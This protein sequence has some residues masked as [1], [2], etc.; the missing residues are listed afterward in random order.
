MREKLKKI[1]SERY[2]Q[3]TIKVVVGIF[4]IL[5][6]VSFISAEELLQFD[7]S[8]SYDSI[9]KTI[10]I[11]NTFGLGR[12]IADIKLNTPIINKVGYGGI[13]KVAEFQV[14]SYENYTEAIE[15]MKFYNMN[16]KAQEIP[17][18]EFEY[19]V[20]G[21]EEINVND[22]KEVC[23]T[24]NK[25]GT[26][27]DC[28]QEIVGT[29][30]ETQEVWT[31]LSK[32]DFLKD[33]IKT[34]GIYTYVNKGDNVEW[35]MN[36]YGKELT[37]WA[38]W[39]ASL[40]SGLIAYYSFDEKTGTNMQNNAT[41]SGAG[42]LYNGTAVNGTTVGSAGKLGYSV[43]LN[44][45]LNTEKQAVLVLMATPT[46][47]ISMCA[48]I[49]SQP[50]LGQR[51][52]IG[53]YNGAGN[54]FR[55]AQR[56]SST[57]NNAVQGYIGGTNVIG[58]TNTTDNTFH[59]VCLTWSDSDDNVSLYTDGKLEDTDTKTGALNSQVGIGIGVWNYIIESVDK[60]FT[61][62]IDEVGMW[63]RRLTDAEITNLYNGGAGI[64]YGGYEPI[65]I[66][67][68]VLQTPTN[69]QN[70]STTSITFDVDV[71]DE[72]KIENVTLYV[73]GSAINYDYSGVNGTYLFN[74][75]L[76]QGK[77]NWS[78]LA[79]NNNSKGNQSDTR[80]FWID[81]TPPVITITYPTNTTY[82][83]LLTLEDNLTIDFNWTTTDLNLN[84]NYSCWYS[85]NGGTTNYTILCDSNVSY[86]STYGQKSIKIWA[87]DTSGNTA[88]A[89]V[90]ATWNY[91][92]LFNYLGNLSQEVYI[93]QNTSYWINVTANSS[94]TSANFYLNG[95]RYTGI[96]TGDTWNVSL[97]IPATQIGNTSFIW[98]L[99]Y[100]GVAQNL[101][102]AY[103]NI[104]N[105]TWILCDGTYSTQYLNISFKDESNDSS[106]KADVPA[107]TWNYYL[108]S[109]TNYKTYTYST[110]SF[111]NNYTYCFAPANKSVKVDY[112]FQYSGITYPQRTY[113]PTELS[114][115]NSMINKT[116]YLLSNVDGIY[117]TFQVITSAE[118]PISG[119]YV[120]ASKDIDGTITMVGEGTT[121]DDGGI[122]FWLNPDF[123]HTF[124]FVKSGYT[125]Y[126][127]SF[128]PTQSLYTI[129]LG[130]STSTTNY[131]Y[132]Q[133][134]NILLTPTNN[135]LYNNT[136]Y[137]FSLDINSTY[138]DITK[139]GFSILNGSG[140]SL[141]TTSAVT[142]GGYLSTLLD[143]SGNGSIIMN[144]YYFTNGTY[145]NYTRNWM[146]LNTEGTDWSIKNFATDLKSYAEAGM[147]GLSLGSFAFGILIFLIIMVSVGIMSYKFGLTSPA[148]I[149]GAI[150]AIVFLLDVG[151]GLMDTLNPVGAVSHFPTIFVAIV[152]IG[153][154]IRESVR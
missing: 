143:V 70:I 98:E 107:S 33:E 32:M 21:I 43:Y 142:N 136:I 115:N 14:T 23:I 87:N 92:M 125:T 72:Q 40:D 96:N 41:K 68:V 62:F 144:Y 80:E 25:N 24:Q 135:S 39:V 64:A 27:E 121:G 63:N 137:N 51:P 85:L 89:N 55:F 90:T 17:I 91:F 112:V 74:E 42:W 69:Y 152:A 95:T 73:D 130:T 150:F 129:S 151:L 2:L 117:V 111:F 120:N 75:T 109:G 60:E 148:T 28:K 36:A 138:W 65:P 9:T 105:I 59:Y 146:V 31:T 106:I 97:E 8:K 126:V 35:V 78:I 38:Y 15:G 123:I 57:Y 81:T 19:K 11:T 5:F 52:F 26:G 4:F 20:K 119:V 47:A 93:T 30:K 147:F 108:G 99:T 86:F 134:V 82:N 7:N 53:G 102:T 113:N 37:E 46:S 154:I 61:G 94:L 13:F 153:L 100:L 3:S 76:T 48:W 29:H 6:L 114:F 128:Q 141:Y 10:T 127:S 50:L 18:K 116:L 139:F 16:N 83:T 44:N 45:T 110:S 79:Y 122:T 58:L 34:I 132:T 49:K 12:T 54:D 88:T 56:P 77:H 66:P 71:T 133:G 124:Y 103:T 22:Y 67:K 140:T 1:Q 145:T 118:Q 84:T 101:T 149:T 104:G 131:D